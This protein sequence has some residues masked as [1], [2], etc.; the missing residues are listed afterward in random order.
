MV[1]YLVK[2][3]VKKGFEEAFIKASLLNKEGTRKEEGNIQFDLS[4]EIENSSEFMLY[5]VYKSDNAVDDHKKT[6][7]YL[8]W[9]ETVEEMMAMP[10][11][12]Q[13]YSPVTG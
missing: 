5:E 9:R 7:H 11:E 8:K 1:V 2:I 13:K 3:H 10:R 4:Q 12:G 6:D